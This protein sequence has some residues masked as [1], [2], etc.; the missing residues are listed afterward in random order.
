MKWPYMMSALSTLVL[1]PCSMQGQIKPNAYQALVCRKYVEIGARNDGDKQNALAEVMKCFED[2]TVRVNKVTNFISGANRNDK[3]SIDV[4]VNGTTKWVH[5]GEV[6][7]FLINEHAAYKALKSWVPK[8]KA[9]DPHTDE[10]VALRSAVD[11]TSTSV[12]NGLDLRGL[13]QLFSAVLNAGAIVGN[14]RN[15]GEEA[16]S[17]K[18][19][20]AAAHLVWES[21]HFGDDGPSRVDFSAKG[22]VGFLPALTLVEDAA[23][24]AASQDK[25]MQ[26]AYQEAFVW[27]IGARVNFQIRTRT[28]SEVSLVA[29]AGQTV[30]G[31]GSV[32][33]EKGG[34]S[35]LFL[36]VGNGAGSSEWFYESGIE[37]NLYGSDLD[38]VHG[39]GSVVSPL[40]YLGFYLRK[41]NR[42][43]KEGDL[44][45]FDSPDRRGVFRFMLDALKVVDKR[46]LG[47]PPRTFALGFGVEHEFPFGSGTKVPSGTKLVF[48]GDIDLLRA[49]R[50]R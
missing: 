1:T 7:V 15:T 38:V 31:T 16:A 41:D 32:L 5:A 47:Q 22:R 21:V 42:F 30:I 8:L 12:H 26:T 18:S 27:D 46:E 50:G 14:G 48:R 2:I 40:F 34:Q 37:Y 35:R 23:P 24:P 9:G 44:A 29:K 19:T 36:P 4:V 11:E 3:D 20:E 39:E 10:V 49:L 28:A 33:V 45:T 6:N 25:D 13:N 43:K 17:D